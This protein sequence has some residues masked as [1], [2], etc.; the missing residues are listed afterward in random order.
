M[1]LRSN[2]MNLNEWYWSIDGWLDSSSIRDRSGD[3]SMIKKKKK[4][5]RVKKSFH[6]CRVAKVMW[7]AG[8]GPVPILSQI[9]LL[10]VRQYIYPYCR[11]LDGR[12]KSRWLT[13]A[14]D[15][16]ETD[17]WRKQLVDAMSWCRQMKLL[18][19]ASVREEMNLQLICKRIKPFAIRSDDV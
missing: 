12:R 3:G 16:Q 19:A 8:G 7:R 9:F 11:S 1:I 13:R 14:G 5:K 2:Q 18:T 4:K 10:T 15:W 17:D 6:L